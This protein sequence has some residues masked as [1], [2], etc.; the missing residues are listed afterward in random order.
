MW[1]R[2]SQGRDREI[3]RKREK[4]RENDRDSFTSAMK[5]KKMRR[6]IEWKILYMRKKLNRM[7]VAVIIQTAHISLGL[8]LKHFMWPIAFCVYWCILG[9]IPFRLYS[10]IA[11]NRATLWLWTRLIYHFFTRLPFALFIV[12]LFCS[13][14][15]A[16]FI[17]CDFTNG[18]IFH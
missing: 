18:L 6:K 3:E 14:N 1:A 9:F 17:P 11:P 7:C 13:L 5:K 16:F 15:L 12:F 8:K 4:K 2:G 10:F